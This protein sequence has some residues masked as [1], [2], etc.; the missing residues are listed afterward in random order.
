MPGPRDTEPHCFKYLQTRSQAPAYPAALRCPFSGTGCRSPP[1]PGGLRPETHQLPHR[2]FI[3][4]AEAQVQFVPVQL[5]LQ[6]EPLPAAPRHG[7]VGGCPR[8]MRLSTGRQRGSA[9][10]GS[11]RF[12]AAQHSSAQHRP[13]RSVP[14]RRGTARPRHPLPRPRPRGARQP[15]P[16]GRARPLPARSGAAPSAHAPE[17]LNTYKLP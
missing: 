1:L 9:R 12:G 6:V 15:P 7:S 13:T 16:R 8:E 11:V 17:P 10:F 14:S 3:Q 4:V 2:H 5:V